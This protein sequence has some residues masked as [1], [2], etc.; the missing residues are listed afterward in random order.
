VLLTHYK[1]EGFIKGYEL[2]KDGATITI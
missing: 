2:D 1:A